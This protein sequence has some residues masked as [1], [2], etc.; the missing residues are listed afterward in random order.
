MTFRQ[1]F[2]VLA[3]RYLRR[4][5]QDLEVCGF[6]ALFIYCDFGRDRKVPSGI[7]MILAKG[8]GIVVVC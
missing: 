7:W 2:L 1:R 3:A 5:K 4:P 8:C 6:L